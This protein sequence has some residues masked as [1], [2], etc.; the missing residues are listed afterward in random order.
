MSITGAPVAHLQRFLEQQ[1]QPDIRRLVLAYSGGLDSRALL[2]ALVELQP[3]HQRPILLVHVHH[4][5]SRFAD[6]W[7]LQAEDTAR[8]YH[9]PCLVKKVRIAAG[10]SLEDLARTARYQAFSSVL[11][12]GDV[13]VLAHHRNDQAE[14]VLLRL[15]RGS[16]VRGLAAMAETGVVPL[17]PR[18]IMCWRPWLGLHRGLIAAYARQQSLS[19]VEDESNTDSA[20]SRNYV[21]HQ[22]LPVL[23]QRWGNV[24]NQ[25]A[26]TSLRMREADDLL[27]E[28][29]QLDYQQVKAGQDALNIPAL[30]VLTTARRNNVLRYWLEQ[31]RLNLPDHSGLLRLWREVGQA[32]N[33]A[34]PLFKWRGVEIR[35]YRQC[36]YAMPP[37]F[38]FDH[39]DID[40]ADLGK[41]LYLPCGGRLDWAQ[42]SRG[43]KQDLALNGRVSIRF[44]AGGE[45]IR[46]AGRQHHHDLKK[47][48]QEAG[49]PPWQRERIPLL[50]IDRQL[51]A[52]IG[53]WVSDEFADKGSSSC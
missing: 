45:K 52:V 48:L 27:H 14:T 50:Y 32:K 23:E 17:Q 5:L 26:E 18:A 30:A 22:V 20:F 6:D 25:L 16:G 34:T 33:D 37:L 47:L 2:H 35:R 44:R 13:L 39:A 7:A 41:A 9:I 12:P 19:W 21:R 46:P 29:A 51:A 1:L 53:Y 8:R 31:Q 42:A 43:V 38:A 24:V 49:V 10:A 36:L 15:M 11:Q 28:L 3:Y 40:W 4:G